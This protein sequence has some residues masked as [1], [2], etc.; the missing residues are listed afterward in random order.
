[1]TAGGAPLLPPLLVRV[2]LLDPKEDDE[3]VLALREAF[4]AGSGAGRSMLF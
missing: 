4:L 3:D 2:P 1:M